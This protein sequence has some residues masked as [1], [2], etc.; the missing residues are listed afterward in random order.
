MSTITSAHMFSIVRRALALS[1]RRKLVFAEALINTLT[2]WV[3]IRFLPYSIWRRWLGTAVNHANISSDLRPIHELGNKALVDI[4]WAH[5]VLDGRMRPMCTCLMFGFSARAMLRRRGFDS[6]LV[7]GV[8]ARKANPDIGLDAH[9]WVMY[10][11]FDV[12]GGHMSGRYTKV[13]AYQ[14]KH[15]D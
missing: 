7:L 11:Q 13:A 14:S 10:Q 15:T 4:A 8:Q 9:A 1:W 3:M 6:V 12:F 2:A 5:R